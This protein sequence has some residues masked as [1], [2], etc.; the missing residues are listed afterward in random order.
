MQ[1]QAAAMV[2][3]R[4][5]YRLV[6]AQ[7]CHI[8]LKTY[9]TYSSTVSSP[10]CLWSC[11]FTH[12]GTWHVRFP[13]TSWQ[14]HREAKKRKTQ[15]ERERE[16]ALV[17]YWLYVQA[18]LTLACIFKKSRPGVGTTGPRHSSRSNDYFI[19]SLMLMHL[20][21]AGRGLCTHLHSITQSLE[22]KWIPTT[23]RETNSRENAEE[24]GHRNSDN[25]KIY[26]SLIS[27][28]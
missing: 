3:V 6:S 7:K 1:T 19:Y 13:A 11:I 22:P 5:R 12:A 2:S 8:T 21:G 26:N 28:I 16:K 10:L 14:T 27:I 24:S 15:R 9:H 20:A 18:R 17:F 25:A 4:L 23:D